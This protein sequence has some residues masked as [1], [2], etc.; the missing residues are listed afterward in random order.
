VFQREISIGIGLE[1]SDDFIRN[2]C[3]NKGLSEKT[4]SSAVDSLKSE[5]ISFYNYVLLGKP[6]IPRSVDIA[7]AVSSI[8][9]AFEQ[10]AFMV[11]MR[12]TN[13]QPHTLTHWL[14][15]RG[16]FHP[17]SIWDAVEVLR[18]LQP[19]YRKRVSIKGL[20]KDEIEPLAFSRGCES[21]SARLVSAFQHWNYDR[22]YDEFLAMVGDCNCRRISDFEHLEEFSKESV[23][24]KIDQ[25]FISLGLTVE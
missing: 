14:W 10:G 6:F 25:V 9:Y 12:V 13:I 17:P 21:C 22:N 18:N 24:D 2:V 19:E 1:S 8:A 16:L 3:L 7:D 4:F 15:E 20:D 23:S 5:N 11:V